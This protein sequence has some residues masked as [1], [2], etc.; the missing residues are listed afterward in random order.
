MEKKLYIRALAFMTAV[1][2][3]A[4]SPAPKPGAQETAAAV[5]TGAENPYMDAAIR[6]AMTGI[7]AEHGGPFGCVI[8][9]DGKIVGQGHNMVLADKDSTAHGEIVAIRNTESAMDTYDL[10]GCELYT[11]G[12]PCPMCLY[13]IL[14]ANI[15]KVYYGCTIEDN[16]AIGFRDEAF[17]Q[18]A[19]GRE[20]LKDFL[21]CI[22][23][24]ACL[25]LFEQYSRMNHQVY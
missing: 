19:G 24:E 15:D 18:L 5:E 21:V 7:T 20:A 1:F 16:A 13:A 17:D 9:K 14:W 25:A 4:C 8:V 10:S 12:E 2:M 23:R 11:T 3:T 6:E 22:D